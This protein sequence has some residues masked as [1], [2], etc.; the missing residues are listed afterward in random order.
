MV[1]LVVDSGCD[2]PDEFLR[3]YGVPVLPHRVSVGKDAFG[4]QRNPAQM[5]HFY[6]R[7]LVDRSRV[8]N[9]GPTGEPEIE[10]VISKLIR[11]GHTDI[12][13]QTINAA[14]SPTYANAVAVAKR[15]SGDAVEIHTVDSHTLFSG[16]GLLA[17]Y[18][19]SLIQKGLTG[20]QVKSRTEEFGRKIAGYAAIQDVYYL[21][22]RG[23]QKNEKSVSWLKAFMARSLDLHPIISMTYQGSAVA[24]TVKTF[25]GSTHRLFQIAEEKMAANALLMPAVVVSIAGPLEQLDNIPGFKSFLETAAKH[26]VK[27]YRSV[28]SL[29]GGINLGPGTVALAI[30]A[31]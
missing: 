9:S 2:L 30:A 7:S 25:D 6:S 17:L 16:Q 3:K 12:V 22:E 29:S 11:Q 20:V 24:D 15:L 8:V 4:D 19:L 23:R 1:Q 14:N 21:R 10:E 26:R 31:K 27:V 5:S 18:T 13:I 28:M